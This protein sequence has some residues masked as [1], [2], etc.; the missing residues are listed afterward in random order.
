MTE[1]PDILIACCGNAMRGDDAFGS[2]VA[3]AMRRE[4]PLPAT[5]VEL[6]MRPAAL[7]DHLPGQRVLLLVDAARV[8]APTDDDA[9]ANH[10]I[11]V[12]FFDPERPALVHDD[13]LST[14]GL[15]IADQLELARRLGMLPPVVRLIA[16][17]VT[18]VALGRPAT[19]AVRALASAAAQRLIDFMN[20]DRKARTELCH[21]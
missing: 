13:A 9:D 19:P 12:D 4:P 2:L 18:T 17:P 1:P 20:R 7:L 11:D 5:L 21:A 3:E 8:D 14:H 15:S 10:L 16:A 6:G